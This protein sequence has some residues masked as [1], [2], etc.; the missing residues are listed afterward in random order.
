MTND[1]DLRPA[2]AASADPAEATAGRPPR[3]R[4]TG[5]LTDGQRAAF[6]TEWDAVQTGFVA[7]PQGTAE[8]ARRLVAELA[9]SVVRRVGEI[10]DAVSRPGSDTSDAA[11]EDGRAGVPSADEEV[12]RERLLRCREA[13]HLLIDS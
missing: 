9:D 12:W 5:L 7:D 4:T 8:A 13:F 1:F 11:A 2:P 10:A 3:P 6:L